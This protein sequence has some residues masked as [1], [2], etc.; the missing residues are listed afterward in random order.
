MSAIGYQSVGSGALVRC[1]L[2]S[3]G[4]ILFF[5]N[6]DSY[7][8]GAYSA[9][10]PV[11]WTLVFAC[12]AAA[13]AV[14]NSHRPMPLLRSPLLFWTG[15][16]F[17]LTTAWAWWMRND[18]EVVQELRD[19]YRSILFLLTFAVIFDEPRARR[20]AVVTVG[21]CV[22]VASLLNVAELLSLVTFVDIPGAGRAVG[23]PAGFYINANGAGMAIALGLA[24]SAAAVPKP[25]RVP[26]L[27]VSTVGAAA[28]FSRAAMICLVL[29]VAWLAWRRALGAWSAVLISVGAFVVLI[30]AI[31]YLQAHDLL[32]DNTAARLR[33]ATDASGRDVL[34]LKAWRM[35]LS[36]PLVGHGL[37]STRVWEETQ[38]A[39]NMFLT[40]GADHGLLGLMAFP[41]LGFALFAS[42]RSSA[43]FALVFMAAGLFSHGLLEDRYALLLMAAAAAAPAPSP[44]PGRLRHAAALSGAGHA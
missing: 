21:V 3:A 8:Y 4:V 40:L 12:A 16:Y 25:W 20:A 37:G 17:V 41:A 36:A 44:E 43:G 13:L 26:L 2:A 14:V 32:N 1:A 38:R 31:S 42:N 6:L 33:L 18:P 24:I 19:R 15:F 7:L 9:P 22:A 29:V 23:R 30:Y 10:P 39:H 5:T 27:L 34:A 28:T 11:Q 35:F